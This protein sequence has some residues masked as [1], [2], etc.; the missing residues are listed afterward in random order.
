VYYAPQ[1]APSR[2]ATLGQKAAA[3][4]A[5]V[6]AKEAQVLPSCQQC[7]CALACVSPCNAYGFNLLKHELRHTAMY[8][9]RGSRAGAAAAAWL[10]A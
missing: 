5:A 1:V 10:L 6:Q 8:C 9:L 4:I 2:N 3:A 7:C